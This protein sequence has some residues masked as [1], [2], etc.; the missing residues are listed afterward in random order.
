[1]KK[2]F[3]LFVL[4]VCFSHSAELFSAKIVAGYIITNKMD[5]IYGSLKLSKFDLSKR[6]LS[7]NSYNSDDLF[8]H[9]FFKPASGKKYQWYSPD[10]V[11]E[12]CFDLDHSIYHFISREVKTILSKK[13]KKYFYRQVENG[14]INLFESRVIQYNMDRTTHPYGM[15]ISE[16]YVLGADNKLIEVCKGS[17]SQTIFEFLS[18]NLKTNTGILIKAIGNKSFRDIVEIVQLYNLYFTQ[19]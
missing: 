2:C 9:V 13:N 15:T 19:L 5:T 3:K 10:D 16:Y 17:K 14:A 1:M 4:L 18:A 12:Y 8:I 7:I 11:Q 6:T